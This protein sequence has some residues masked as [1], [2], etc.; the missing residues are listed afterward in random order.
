MGHVPVSFS[1]S[2]SA[3]MRCADTIDLRRGGVVAE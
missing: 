3:L 1:R 2:A